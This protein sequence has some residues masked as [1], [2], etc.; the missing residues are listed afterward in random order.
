MNLLERFDDEVPGDVVALAPEKRAFRFAGTFILDFGLTAICCLAALEVFAEIPESIA[1][2]AGVLFFGH[3]IV[4]CYVGKVL[5]INYLD[6]RGGDART[7][8]LSSSLVDSG[9]YAWSRNPTYLLAFVQ[10]LSWAAMLLWVQAFEPFHGLVVATMLA[11]PA[12]FYFVNERKIMPSEEA[13]LRKLH[14]A[15]FDA[16]A[17]RVSRWLGRARAPL[18]G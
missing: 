5:V 10:F 3:V 8:V 2:F 7:Y 9:P 13:T 11:V 15:A 1:A 14:G 12:A 16:Y 6:N 4:G 18:Q 17:A